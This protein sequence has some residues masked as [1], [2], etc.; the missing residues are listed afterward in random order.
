[1][2]GPRRAG[3]AGRGRPAE[4]PRRARGR[5]LDSGL[6]TSWGS[7]LGTAALAQ[8]SASTPPPRAGA[9][10]ELETKP[11]EEEMPGRRPW[12]CCRRKRAGPGEEV[13]AAAEG[14]RV[15]GTLRQRRLYESTRTVHRHTCPVLFLFPSLFKGQLTFEPLRS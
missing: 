11:G 8:C 5:R 3:K 4:L 14:R 12:H 7:V 6:I 9:E 2:K 15:Q 1:M 10:N 13:A